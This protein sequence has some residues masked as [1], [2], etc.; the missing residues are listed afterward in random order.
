MFTKE[1]F[2]I[3]GEALLKKVK[4]LIAEG[5]IRKII[6]TDKNGKELMTFPLTVGVA[7]ALLMP[8]FAAVGAMAALIGECTITVE[9]EHDEKYTGNTD[10]VKKS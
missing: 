8:V 6:I 5:N 9:R 3:D 4:E 10:I 2:A 1:S 7:G